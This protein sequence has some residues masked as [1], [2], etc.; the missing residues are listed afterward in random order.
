M[1]DKSVDKELVSTGSPSNPTVY[2][3]SK[4]KDQNLFDIRKYFKKKDTE[5]LIPTKKGIS[6][7][8]LGFEALLGIIKNNEKDIL[9][10]FSSNDDNPSKKLIKKLQDQ[11]QKVQEDIFAAKEY[12][13][14]KDKWSDPT[15]FKIN[16]DGD[17]R[18]LIFNQNHKVSKYIDSKINEEEINSK[19]IINLIMLSFQHS[20]DTYSDDQEIKVSDFVED[21]KHNWGIILK[22]YIKHN[23]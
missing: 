18:I 3:L 20:V 8:K 2:K 6:L 13:L 7:N 5:E 1:T 15:F 19:N 9:D 10:W 21:L 4:F 16:Y 11:S 23:E 12:S 22:N 17:K 14:K